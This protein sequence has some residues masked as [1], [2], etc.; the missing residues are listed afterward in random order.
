MTSKERFLATIRG[1]SVDKVPVYHQTLS[2]HACSVIL[3]RE[4]VCV[5]GAHNQW[6]EMNAL[7]DNPDCGA[8]HDQ[9]C[10]ADALAITQ[11]CQMDLLRLE[12]WRWARGRPTQKIDDWTFLF[13]DPDGDWYTMTYHP[14][15]ELF[16]KK[17]G[18]QAGKLKPSGNEDVDQKALIKEVEELE[19]QAKAFKSTTDANGELKASIEKYPQYLVRHGGGTVCIGLDSTRQLMGVAL[20]PELYARFMMAR[21][22]ILAARMPSMGLAGLDLNISGG[23]FCSA[24]HRRCPTPGWVIPCPIRRG[25]K[26]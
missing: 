17:E 3:G 14:D 23:D 22:K 9:R 11:A 18:P 4:N 2:G 21:A 12:Y 24:D 5:G 15:I 20:W 1:E 19:Q 16:T 6:I 7:W 26:K 8:A 10:E 13:G 25:I